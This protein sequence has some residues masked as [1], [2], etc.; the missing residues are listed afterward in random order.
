MTNKDLLKQILQQAK[1]DY[2]KSIL[3]NFIFFV[4]FTGL[5]IYL[6]KLI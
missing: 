4:L 5:G 6:T 2:K 3:I 1:N